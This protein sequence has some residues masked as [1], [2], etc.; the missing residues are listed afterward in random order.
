MILFR[1]N[2]LQDITYLRSVS[3]D[4]ESTISQWHQGH[5][6]QHYILSLSF[7]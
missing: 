4:T 5:S 7:G 6:Q 3:Y 1:N 2:T